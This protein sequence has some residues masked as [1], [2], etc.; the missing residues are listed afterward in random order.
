MKG[1]DV[2]CK[3]QFNAHNPTGFNENIPQRKQ[4]TFYN[5]NLFNESN[6]LRIF[7]KRNV[8]NGIVQRDQ[9]L[10]CNDDIFKFIKYKTS[11]TFPKRSNSEKCHLF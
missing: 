10:K 7:R 4:T 8:N 5:K 3:R 1:V 9:H 11:L 2:L 6:N